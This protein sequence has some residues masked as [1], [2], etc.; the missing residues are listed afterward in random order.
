MPALYYVIYSSEEIK[1][2]AISHPYKVLGG[3]EGDMV[4][5]RVGVA[6]EVEGVAVD[7]DGGDVGDLQIYNQ[8]IDLK[9]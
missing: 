3:N 2:N 9:N 8:I 6:V 1:G 7:N 4:G 5:V